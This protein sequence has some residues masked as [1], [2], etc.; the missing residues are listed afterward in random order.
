MIDRF[1]AIATFR[2]G[3]PRFDQ[4]L[5]PVGES[6]IEFVV[7]KRPDKEV[8]QGGRLPDPQKQLTAHG[9]TLLTGLPAKGN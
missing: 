1:Q 4:T 5:T 9:H 6:A 2:Y 7:R 8:E 3:L